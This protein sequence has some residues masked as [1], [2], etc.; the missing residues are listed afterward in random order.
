MQ[1]EAISNC[2]GTELLMGRE[3]H[4]GRGG[5][6]SEKGKEEKKKVKTKTGPG[7]ACI[8]PLK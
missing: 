4:E 8:T 1:I 7:L 3:E 6:A 2:R 5:G